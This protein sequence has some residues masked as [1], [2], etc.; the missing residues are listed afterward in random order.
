MSKINLKRTTKTKVPKTKQ[1]KLLGGQVSNFCNFNQFNDRYV[2]NMV[3][4]ELARLPAGSYTLD[5]NQNTGELYFDRFEPNYDSIIDLPSAEYDLVMR[6]VDTFL[7]PETKQAF[8]DYGFL[9]KFNILLEGT[10][11]TGKTVIVN[12]VGQKVVQGGG[13]IIFNPHPKL[14][15]MAFKIL[16]DVQPELNTMVI[17][18][19]FDETLARH[20]EALLSILD[21]EVQKKNVMFLA[22]T[23]HVEK[24]PAR[25]LRP[26]RFARVINVK[27]PG[28]EAR[29]VY[30]QKKLKP[31]DFAEIPAWVQAT[32][33]LSIDEVKETVQSV[34]CLG[35]TLADTVARIRAVKAKASPQHDHDD[36]DWT[37]REQDQRVAIAA[38]Q[39]MKNIANPFG[40]KQP[41]RK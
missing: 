5:Y 32:D 19:E 35:N 17:F 36:D 25:L 15:E 20:E 9:Y 12:R 31:S 41:K 6:E 33:G 13:V 3:R 7:K 8:A 14:L 22:T 27:Y 40:Q 16:E 1:Q 2:G 23:N 11:G 4:K 29:T 18:E 21:G 26:G 34:K 10:H 39:F 30:L 24:I 38:Q 37:A 28:A